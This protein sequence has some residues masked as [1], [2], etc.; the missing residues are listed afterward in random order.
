MD[1]IAYMCHHSPLSDRKAD[2]EAKLKS[3]GIFD[4][5]WVTEFDSG[6][7]E[8]DW[9]AQ[10]LPLREHYFYLPGH[11]RTLKRQEISLTM[12][13]LAAWEDMLQKGVEVGLILEDDACFVDGFKE[14]YNE[15]LDTLSAD[16][17]KWDFVFP[18]TC[19]GLTKPPQGNGYTLADTSRCGHGYAI[20]LKT[21]EILVGCL[22][23][24]NYPVDWYFNKIIKQENLTTV[25]AEPAL[26]YQSADYSSSIQSNT[27]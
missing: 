27:I 2:M 18:G 7:L 24:N 15:L 9:V 11:H 16:N 17:V 19:C 20:T 3:A 14:K 25:W 8:L 12:K 13:H 21:A 23:K 22:S 6:E 1:I 26:I 10:K 5:T 4:C